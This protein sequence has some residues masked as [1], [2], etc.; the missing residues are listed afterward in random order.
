MAHS[1]RP[2]WKAAIA[3]GGTF[4]RGRYSGGGA[5]S[6]QR[7]QLE[8]S[9][10]SK[11]KYRQPQQGRYA[12]PTQDDLE[13]RERELVEGVIK[14]SEKE[15]PEQLKDALGK[16]N[17]QDNKL[18][19]FDDQDD[20]VSSDSDDS[21]SDS[22]SDEESSDDEEALNR[23]LQRIRKEREEEA[24]RKQEEEE[25]V[26]AKLGLAPPLSV[27]SKGDGG[28][29]RRWDADVVFQNQ[30]RTERKVGKRFINDTI[31]N[32]FH[33]AFLKKYIQ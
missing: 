5:V 6:L 26:S 23:E 32:D 18:E 21:D 29:K 8:F 30:A 1:H 31:R 13:R 17:A 33:R 12:A 11:L 15:Q 28:M 7:S 20:Q 25:L 4:D 3:V 9:G 16:D 27:S 14:E 19:K 24:K 10:N 22:D 2:Q